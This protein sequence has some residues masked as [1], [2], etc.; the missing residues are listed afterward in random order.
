MPLGCNN[1][2][3]LEWLLTVV[4]SSAAVCRRCIRS[5]AVLHAGRT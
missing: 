1:L 4:G 3:T 5:A 2:S